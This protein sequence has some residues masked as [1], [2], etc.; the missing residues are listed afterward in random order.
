MEIF[1]NERQSARLASELTGVMDDRLLLT[2]DTTD[3]DEINDLMFRNA[4]FPTNRVQAE[5]FLNSEYGCFHE[6]GMKDVQMIEELLSKYGMRGHYQYT[7]SHGKVR[8]QSTAYLEEALRKEY[9][10]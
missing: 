1:K 5:A 2:T 10:L 4:I 7:K 9:K 8:F 3:I 6:L